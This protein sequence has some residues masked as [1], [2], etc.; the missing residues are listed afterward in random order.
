MKDNKSKLMFAG[1][2][3]VIMFFISNRFS[4]IYRAEVGQTIERTNN[5][6][7]KVLADFIARPFDLSLNVKDLEIG[8]I[9]AFGIILIYLYNTFGR[10]NFMIGK[11]HGSAEWGQPKDISKYLETEFSKNILFSQDV[12]LSMNTRKTFK[13]NNVLIV[14]GSGSGKTRFY[15]K[16][17]LMQMHS[18]YVIT[19]P[20]GSLVKE[21]GKLLE[22]NGYKV[23][24]FDLINMEKSG[25][26][27]PFNYLRDE[28]DILKLVNNIIKNTNSE[29]GKGTKSDFWEK[30][31]VALLSALFGFVFFEGEKHEKNIA[32]VMELLRLAE[33][34][35]EDE[36][37]KSPLDLIFE[38]LKTRNPNHFAL[39]QY[40]IFKLGAGKTAKSI[41]ISVG[42]RLSPFNI[43]SLLNIMTS[44]DLEIDKIGEEKTAF[45]II[46]PD[47]DTTFNFVSAV[48]YQQMFDSLFYKADFEY[49]GRLPI[50]TRF[51]LDEFANIGLIPNFEV[52][53][54]TMRSREISV[55]VILQNLAQ[56]KNI[57]KD[58]WETITGNCDTLVFLG[59]REQS[60][61]KYIS[62]MLG[63]TTIDM[64]TTTENKGQTGGFSVNSQVLGRDLM[65]PDE[66]GL[67][68]NEECIVLIRGIRPFKS[69]KYDITK[70]S[71]YQKL[72]DF[73]EKNLYDYT[74]NRKDDD[75]QFHG[76]LAD[77]NKAL[78]SKA[79]SSRELEINLDEIAKEEII[80]DISEMISIQD[81]ELA[82]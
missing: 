16:P 22:E 2:L 33:V 58:S 37:F 63:K 55:N 52:Y 62:E 13:N 53:I 68:G 14:G 7:D 65:T 69:K 3:T 45:F 82:V 78:E 12:A 50:H 31:E 60:T 54:A 20:K 46:L 80:S 49:N 57:Y 77:Y 42:V 32:T 5:A 64:R 79:S 6:L 74:K 70:H 73:D 59:G 43:P 47:S 40:E 21:C 35:E 8:L 44:D 18:S 30:S 23:K 38:D 11:E 66:V 39:K 81:D 75:Y 9:G 17:N 72:S 51:L 24:V 28:K 48:M 15:L 67:L 36:S 26:Y 4:L 41:L 10:N 19:D 56:L 1:I 61:L 34:K 25:K 76:V 71:N 27:N 29:S